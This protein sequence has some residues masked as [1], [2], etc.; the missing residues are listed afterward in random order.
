[1]NFMTGNYVISSWWRKI[2]SANLIFGTFSSKKTILFGFGKY[3][4]YLESPPN[5]TYLPNWILEHL[6]FF[7]HISLSMIRFRNQTQTWFTSNWNCWNWRFRP[8]FRPKSG[9]CAHQHE[10]LIKNPV[11]IWIRTDSPVNHGHFRRQMS[12]YWPFRDKYQISS[13]KH[14]KGSLSIHWKF[15]RSN[16]PI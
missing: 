13:F 5:W 15:N 9:L 16:D 7:R 3:F 1:M 6:P 8:K 4:T 10:S 12:D 14:V 11:I 2:V